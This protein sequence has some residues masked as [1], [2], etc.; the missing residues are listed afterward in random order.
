[1]RRVMCVN[2]PN[3]PVQRLC[4]EKPGLRDKQMVVVSPQAVGGQ[5]VVFCSA[6]AVRS[7]IRPGMPLAEAVASNSQLCIEEEN[8]EGDKRSL[9]RL[10]RWAQRFS[11]I[12][13]LE[14][15]PRPDSLL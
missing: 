2:L 5:K 15:N 13:G 7:G 3:W 12:V 14:E 1:M 10:A 6:Q 9:K 4:H 11:P 8:L